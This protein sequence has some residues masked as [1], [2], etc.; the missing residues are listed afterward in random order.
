MEL[1]GRNLSIRMKGEDVKL[2]QT[3]LHYFGFTIPVSER[4]KTFF[5][6]GTRKAIES[7][8]KQHNL[9][10]TGVVDQDMVVS[11]NTLLEDISHK[12]FTVTGTIKLD[13]IVRVV[14]KDL[15]NEELLGPVRVLLG[16][17]AKLLSGLVGV[18]VRDQA[19]AIF[20]G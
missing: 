15:R 12:P 2:L 9:P 11:M 6:V 7:F 13:T 19:I 20:H 8:Q 4:K 14:D 18:S 3:E 5:G 16:E 17:A 1:N 10:V